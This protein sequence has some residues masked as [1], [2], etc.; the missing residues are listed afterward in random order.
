MINSYIIIIIKNFKQNSFIFSSSHFHSILDSSF[1][2]LIIIIIIININL[3]DIIEE[4][5]IKIK[6]EINFCCCCF[7]RQIFLIPFNNI[8]FKNNEMIHKSRQFDTNLKV[9]A[10]IHS[11]TTFK[12]NSIILFS[13]QKKKEEIISNYILFLFYS[14]Y[15]SNRIPLLQNSTV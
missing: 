15:Y 13:T 11:F 3:P 7:I 12:S 2:L 9:I 10:L 8:C 1:H 6:M 14:L 4:K 5:K